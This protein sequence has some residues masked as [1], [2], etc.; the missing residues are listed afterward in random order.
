[1]PNADSILEKVIEE[2][3]SPLYQLAVG[4]ALV[5]FFYGVFK[6]IVDMNDPEKKNHGKDHLLY[7]VIG[8]F[9]ILSVGGIIKF[10][11]GIFGC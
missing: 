10:F 9:I 6:F 11:D 5:Y 4:L 8:L 1:M 7:G 2:I 3:F